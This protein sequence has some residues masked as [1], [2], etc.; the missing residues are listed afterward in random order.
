MAERKLGPYRDSKT[1]N[2]VADALLR[3]GSKIRV[4]EVWEPKQR[5]KK[6][7]YCGYIYEEVNV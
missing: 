2:S 1:L 3:L 5:Y 4:E 6:D 7:R